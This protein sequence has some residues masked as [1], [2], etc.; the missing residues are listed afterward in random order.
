MKLNNHHPSSRQGSQAVDKIYR[1]C[2]KGRLDPQRAAW[3]DDLGMDYENGVTVLT[4]NL[5]DQPALYGVLLKIRDLGL[6]LVSVET[7]D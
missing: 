6:E 3:F 7:I 4:G 1:I 2:V 5:P